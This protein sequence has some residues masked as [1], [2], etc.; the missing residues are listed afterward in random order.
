MREQLVQGLPSTHGDEY[1]LNTTT[2]I[3]HAAR[4]SPEQEIVFRTDDGG[5]PELTRDDGGMRGSAAALGHDRDRRAHDRLPVRI[6]RLRDEDGSRFER[7]HRA[8]I[9]D[10]ARDAGAD[11]VTDR[12]PGSIQ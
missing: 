11:A 8:R 12:E 9:R 2:L 5:D 3:R 4:T 1:P 6:R 7:A 10:D